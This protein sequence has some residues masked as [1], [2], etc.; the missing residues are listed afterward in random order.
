MF[1]CVV[2]CVNCVNV[3]PTLSVKCQ[4]GGTRCQARKMRMHDRRHDERFHPLWSAKRAHDTNNL[5]SSTDWKHP[6]HQRTER[7][8][9]LGSNWRNGLGLVRERRC[10]GIH[11]HIVLVR[12]THIWFSWLLYGCC[13]RNFRSPTNLQWPF[14][15]KLFVHATLTKCPATQ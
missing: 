15:L 9:R 3:N 5:K 10:G 6:T 11:V 4:H 1:T 2:Q 8:L 12:K 7:R 13:D 14:K